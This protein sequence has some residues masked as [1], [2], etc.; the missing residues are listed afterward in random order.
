MRGAFCILVLLAVPAMAR[1]TEQQPDILLYDGLEMSLSTGWGHPSPLETYYYQSSFEYPFEGHA[2]NNYRGHVAV[3]KIDAGKFYLSKIHIEDYVRDPNG[4][5]EHVVDSYEPNEYG[6]KAKSCPPSENGDVLADWFSGILDC[7]GFTDG[8]Y[9][10]YLFH[11]RDGNVVDAETV[12]TQ[13]YEVLYSSPPATWNDELRSK[14]RM[15]VLN[16]NYITYY[17]RLGENDA[18]EYEGQACRL[19]TSYERLSPIFGLYDNEHLNWPYNWE[20]T[21][22]S[23]APHC[24]WLIADERLYL[25]GMELYSGLSFYSI[26]TETLDLSALFP[27]RVMDGVIDANWVNGVYLIKHGH[28]TEEYAGWPGYTFTVFNVTEFTY[29]RIEEGRLMESY[30]VPEDFDP[31]NLPED[32]DPGLRGIIE[33][34]QLPSIFS[35][36]PDSS[37]AKRGQA[38]DV[39]SA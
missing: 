7:Y 8:A 16:E 2:T 10:S 39:P 26:D 20:S 3:W 17:F 12:T 19:D 23:G 11:I 29:A 18:I 25:T 35:A 1:A 34:Y 13:E 22:K 33:D 4:R 6:V 5:Y 37:D 24:Q 38:V 15:L 14:A 32:T 36:P 21:E 27:D 28:V 30:T 31:E 9:T